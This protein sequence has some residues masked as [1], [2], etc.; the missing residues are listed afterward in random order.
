MACRD[1]KEKFGPQTHI[2]IRQVDDIP[3]TRVGKHR[4][5]VS[6]VRPDFL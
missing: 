6:E 1:V 2:T 5:I 3:L 4:N